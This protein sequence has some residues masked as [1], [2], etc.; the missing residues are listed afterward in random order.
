MQEY[1]NLFNDHCEL[2]A[3]IKNDT[4]SLGGETEK[5]IFIAHAKHSDYL[6]R[7]TRDERRL[8]SMQYKCTRRQIV[9][10]LDAILRQADSPAMK[11]STPFRKRRANA[12]AVNAVTL[13]DLSQDEG[14][15]GK[16][17]I[18]VPGTGEDN[19]LFASHSAAIHRIDLDI[20]A[21]EQQPCIVCGGGH[22]FDSCNVLKN[23]SFLRDHYIRY[24]Q[25][26]RREAT[27]RSEAFSG[28]ESHIPLRARK[29]AIG[30]DKGGSKPRKPS[31]KKKAPVKKKTNLA[32]AE[33]HD[34]SPNGESDTSADFQN[35]RV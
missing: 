12:I 25:N 26:L 5:G 32:G 34:S 14:G 33:E 6:Q 19:Q 3:Y 11:K 28:Q 24:C 15:D 30:P 18:D 20:H 17:C 1:Y 13:E 4:S 35:G 29:K 7:N 9:E 31:P 23:T 10:T 21:V 27:A 16:E 22:R 2:R 8:T